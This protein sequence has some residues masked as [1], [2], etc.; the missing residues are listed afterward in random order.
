MA[1]DR[2]YLLYLFKKS[3][4]F[5][6]RILKNVKI[7]MFKFYEQKE[8]DQKTIFLFQALNLKINAT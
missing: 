4:T 7:I 2:Y 1:I 3:E 8:L 6:T 5:T